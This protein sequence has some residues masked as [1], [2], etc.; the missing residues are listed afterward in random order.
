MPFHRYRPRLPGGELAP[1]PWPVSLYR[2]L[3]HVAWPLEAE[4]ELW[5]V[6]LDRVMI[7]LGFLVFC[8]HNEV[9]FHYL[10]ANRQDMD[11]LLTGM[12]TYLILVELQIRCFQLAWHKDRFRALLQRFY[13]EIYVSEVMEPLLFARIQRQMLATRVNSTV[14]LLTLFNFF[15]VPVTNVIYHRREMLYKQV[16][17]FDNTQLHFFIPLLVL[18]FWVGFIITSMLFGE[19]NVMG[20]LMMHLNARYVQ[21]GQDLRRSAQRLLKRSSSLNVATGYRLILTHILRRNAA[22]RDFGQRVEDEFTL[23]IFV[24]FAFSAGLLCALFFKA[25]TN[26]WANVAYIMWFLAK[27]ME[28]LALGMLGSTLLKT[29]DELGMMYYTANWEQVIH[30]SDNVGENVKLMKLVTLAIQLNSRPFFITGLNYFRVSLTAVLK[31]IQ[32][33]FSYF[34]FL[35]S[36]R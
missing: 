18:N 17:P 24:M 27:F 21:L 32:G 3:N 7:F 29:T 36:M 34:T 25:F 9:D 14:Y 15:L 5:T 22:L 4:S 2:I 35:N 1:M 16:Y 28:L 6:L 26:P 19:L 11:N 13:A 31:I 20:E 8:E 33:A 30:Q 23:R 10:I 12:P